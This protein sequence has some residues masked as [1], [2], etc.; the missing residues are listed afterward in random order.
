[1]GAPAWLSQADVL[2][3]AKTAPA[4][5]PAVPAGGRVPA[6]LD[7]ANDLASGKLKGAPSASEQ[8]RTLWSQ[9]S[10]LGKPL[11]FVSQ[12]L[13]DVGTGIDR[14]LGINTSGPSP[15]ARYPGAPQQPNSAPVPAP[16][17]SA[18]DAQHPLLNYG[19]RWPTEFA[20]SA[21]LGEGV[22]AGVGA[23]MKAAGLAA[24]EGASLL[25]RA[26]YAL[27]RSMAMGAAYGVQQPTG[28]PT[29]NAA[30]GAAVG[31]LFEGAAHA[32]GK[33]L[34]AGAEAGQALWRKFFPKALTQPEVDTQVGSYLRTLGTPAAVTPRSAPEGV[35]LTTAAHADNPQLLDLQAKERA[36]GHAV[37][38]HELAT[39]NDA[40]IVN[41]LRQHLAPQADSSA[42]STN[43]HDLLQA[44]QKRGRAAVKAA[45]APFDEA[46]GAVYLERGPVQKALRE[47]YDA[48]L[49]AHQEMLPARV[50]E[51]MEADHPLHLTSDIEDLGARLSDAIG[52][53]PRGTPAARA[54]MMMRDALNRGVEDAPLAN[55]PALGALNYDPARNPLPGRNMA[56]PDPREDSILQ[57][58]AKHHAGLSFE[59]GAAQGLDPA[60]MRSRLARVG[61]RRAFRHG[62]VGFDQAAETLAQHGYPVTDAHGN[63]DPNALLNAIDSE[64]R[65]RPVY[66]VANTRAGDELAH[67]AA[68]ATPPMR[69]PPPVGDVAALAERAGQVDP[70]RAAAVMDGW[71][72]DSPETLARVHAELQAIAEPPQHSDAAEL[73][74]NAKAANKAF[75]DRF[76]QGTARDTEARSWLSKWLSG[77][78]DPGRF[79]TE[80]TVL[81]SRTR[82]VLDAFENP[83]EREQMRQALRNHYVNRLLANTRAAVPGER[84]L[85]ADA[86][87]RARTTNAALERV[88]LNPGERDLLDR[89]TQAARDNAK[90]LQRSIN[91]SSETASLL[92][93]QQ[94]KDDSILAAGLSH[95]AKGHPAIGILA[96]VLPSIARSPDASEALQRTL[97]SALLDPAAYNRV[98]AAKSPEAQG[99]LRLLRGA[100]GPSQSALARGAMFVAPRALNAP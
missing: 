46:K 29:T 54:L 98:M 3:G 90:I 47:A 42:L 21:P 69:E 17:M 19:V 89:Y 36:G 86:L 65:G 59:E 78:K 94:G 75:R 12:G 7:Q 66:S 52:S 56:A 81:P 84:L 28:N 79:L 92:K 34:G 33:L 91:G 80:A 5:A 43:A 10:A 14:L 97:M 87:A 35:S 82:A 23:G 64:L 63:Y 1:M 32:G 67:E 18:L 53:A 99:L 95:I 100:A 38:F 71:T 49:P 96:H 76:P 51:V 13:N 41:G 93:H 20:A 24:P 57:F 22:G 45:Y 4:N 85:N 16:V 6:W 25:I 15:Q 44:A 68:T 9:T 70:E 55:Q 83:G 40:A 77:R 31:P 39:Q 26:L 88:L 74:K 37:P 30:V 50:R 11:T 2:A 61:I 73:W 58:M 60:D 72:D 27:P 62:G 48:L 8:A